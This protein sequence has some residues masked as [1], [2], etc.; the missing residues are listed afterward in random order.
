MKL[1][2]ATDFGTANDFLSGNGGKNFEEN[3]F[4]ATSLKAAK[5]LVRKQGVP[6]QVVCDCDI[7]NESFA[8]EFIAWLAVYIKQ[9]NI[10]VIFRNI[11]MDTTLIG[12]FAITY[13]EFTKWIDECA[14]YAEK[15]P[16]RC[17]KFIFTNRKGNFKAIVSET[18]DTVVF[19]KKDVSGVLCI[20]KT[21][22]VK[23][24]IMHCELSGNG[25]AVLLICS[26]P[27]FPSSLIGR[28]YR[29]SCSGWEEMKQNEKYSEGI[30][31]DPLKTYSLSDNGDYVVSM[32][33]KTKDPSKPYATGYDL[34]VIP[35]D[36]DYPFPNQKY[37][38]S[39]I[40]RQD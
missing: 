6:D 32:N 9:E 34:E 8:Y 10:S 21:L 36:Q 4:V 19:Y 5:D 2:I 15:I 3:R 17:K 14:D 30:S 1:I 29:Y 13:P 24:Q 37:L 39:N 18:R 12:K 22:N 26:L 16:T 27:E 40:A 7:F 11:F 35:F 31:I 33:Q 20:E 23:E 28:Y 38:M 25:N